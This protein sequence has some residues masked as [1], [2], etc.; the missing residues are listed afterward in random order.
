MI[1]TNFP[2]RGRKPFRDC[3]I[4]TG[5]RNDQNQLPRKG[6]ETNFSK[7]KT[8]LSGDQNQLPRKGTETNEC[9]QVFC[10]HYTGDQNQLPRKGTETTDN[11]YLKHRRS[12]CDQNQL[13]RKGT[14]T[15]TYDFGA[16]CNWLGIKTNFPVR[17]RKHSKNKPLC[18]TVV[19]KI[20][21]NFPVRGRKPCIGVQMKLLDDGGIKTNFPVRGRKPARML[22]YL[23]SGLRLDQNQLPRKGTE[24]RLYVC[25][26]VTAG[27]MIKTNFPV[28]GRKPTRYSSQTQTSSF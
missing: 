8:R 28:R 25:C 2:V 27:L 7:L 5:R 1:K 18:V 23:P 21:T 6:T 3:L 12:P 9:R 19:T 22:G 15:V 26:I 24:T 17:G 20:K 11:G 14:E 4:F 16:V 10:R 13:P